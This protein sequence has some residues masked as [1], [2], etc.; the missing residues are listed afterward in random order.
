MQYVNSVFVS[1]PGVGKDPF[2]PK[3]TRWIPKVTTNAIPTAVSFSF[4]SLKGISGP[5]NKRLAIIN[6]R[7][8]EVG[9]VADLKAAGQTVRVTCVEIRDDGVVVS[10]NDQTQKLS[11]GGKP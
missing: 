4:L 5:K 9:E 10:I 8:F 1:T 11:L 2:F 7:T 3:S 6:N